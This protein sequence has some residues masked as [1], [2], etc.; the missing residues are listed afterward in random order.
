MELMNPPAG[1]SA[2]LVHKYK[3]EAHQRILLPLNVLPFVLIALTVFL[4]GDYDRRGRSRQMIVAGTAAIA[5]EVII[6]ALLNGASKSS[7]TL[8]Y[9]IYN[10]RHI[11]F[12]WGGR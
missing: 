7:L 9:L 4:L 2:K 8:Y 10:N 11:S 1:L 6:L 5:F 12:T 3:I